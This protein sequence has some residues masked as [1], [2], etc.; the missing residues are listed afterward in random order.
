MELQFLHDF[1]GL[2]GQAVFFDERQH[3][4][5]CRCEGCGKFEDY[6]CF[7]ALEFFL[8]IA[9]THDAQEH[10]VHADRG[11]DDVG[12]VAFVR[13]G[14]EIFDFSAGEFGVLRQV[15]ISA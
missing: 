14:I 5:F 9:V 12:G 11:F 2:F 8:L 13:L 1:A 15:E 3:S 10:T 6:A 4:Q 7:T